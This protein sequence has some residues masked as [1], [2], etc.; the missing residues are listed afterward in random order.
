MLQALMTLRV[1]EPPFLIAVTT[2]AAVGLVVL[3][4][5][6][7]TVRSAL[8]GA[9][10]AIVGVLIGI[11]L[12]WLVSDVW[13]TF[14]LP[15]TFVTKAWVAA[16]FGGL[17][18]GI[19]A[20]VTRPWWRRVIAVICIPLFVLTA[21]AW[22]NV[23]FGAYN[24]LNDALGITH[25]ATFHV[26]DAVEMNQTEDP[27]LGR[28]WH[29]PFGMPASGKIER[30]T[31]PATLSH[32]PA[33]PAIV[34]LPPA[35]LVSK[36]PTLPVIEMFS[37]QPGSPEDMVD[38]ARVGTYLNRYAAAHK[39]LA[40]IV[41]IPDQLGAPQDNPMCV[42][43][44]LGNAATYLTKDVPNWIRSHLNVGASR[45]DWTVAGYSEGGA[46][47]M[48]FGAGDPQLFGSIIDVSGEIA[49][50]IGASTV[51][52]GFGGSEVAYEQATPLYL[53]KK[54]APFDTWA[55]FGYGTADTKYGAGLRETAEAAKAAGMTTTVIAADGSGH[56]WNTVRTVLSKALPLLSDHLG[57]GNG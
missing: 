6:R 11:I 52:K 17:A 13:D 9:S 36:P 22:I 38:T 26:G 29:A 7:Y 32:F 34:Y 56:D 55:A 28:D 18:V 47:A 10:V 8:V 4:A 19:W 21:A 39:G 27:H 15:L 5:R 35:A 23:D 44:P 25:Y 1:D 20:I 46:C 57:L 12:G 24:D 42:D 2:L 51:K 31:I 3:F 48:Q 43:S 50:S 37:G 40:P 41:V 49:P 16:L 54:N 53:L 30:V 45:A 33:R 14:G